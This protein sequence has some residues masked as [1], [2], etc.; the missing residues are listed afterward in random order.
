MTQEQIKN[1]FFIC[2]SIFIFFI[3]ISLFGLLHQHIFLLLHTFII[4]LIA[5]QYQKKII[6]FP[7]FLLCLLSY[8]HTHIFGSCLIYMLPNLFLGKYFQEHLQAKITIPYLILIISLL[9]KK[10]SLFFM[11]GYEISWYNFLI[12]IMLNL[13][14]LSVFIIVNN[15]LKEKI[16]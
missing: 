8:L 3:D 15:L 13:L 1:S 2:L 11:T 4:F 6:C 7:L 14:P 16:I 9:L 12:L 5:Q 10:Q